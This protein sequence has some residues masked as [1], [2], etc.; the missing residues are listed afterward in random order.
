MFITAMSIFFSVTFVD[1]C[2]LRTSLYHLRWVGPSRLAFYGSEPGWLGMVNAGWICSIQSKVFWQRDLSFFKTVSPKRLRF[3]L[4]SFLNIISF[5]FNHLC[6]LWIQFSLV[7][8]L[9]SSFSIFLS[10]YLHLKLS[11]E[12]LTF[13]SFNIW[14]KKSKSIRSSHLELVTWHLG[15]QIIFRNIWKSS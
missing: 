3:Y 1:M 15:S 8:A 10:W 7:A 5:L 11:P 13:I 6:L 12:F 4:R 9:F 2:K 14:R